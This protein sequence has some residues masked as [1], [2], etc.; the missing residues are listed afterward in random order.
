MKSLGDC[1][2][3]YRWNPLFPFIPSVWNPLLK[4]WVDPPLVTELSVNVKIGIKSRV[5]LDTYYYFF[6]KPY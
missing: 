1:V 5:V 6:A 2:G 3:T 4:Q